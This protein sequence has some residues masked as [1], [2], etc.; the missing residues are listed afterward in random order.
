MTSTVV[1]NCVIFV[2]EDDNLKINVLNDGI[3][4]EFDVIKRC[5]DAVFSKERWTALVNL[6]LTNAVSGGCAC[7]ITYTQ[8]GNPI[9]V[10]LTENCCGKFELDC[11]LTNISLVEAPRHCFPYRCQHGDG[12]H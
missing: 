3:Q 7:N 12:C 10:E 4:S 2:D 8:A 11:R 9:K 1:K 5:N 6:L